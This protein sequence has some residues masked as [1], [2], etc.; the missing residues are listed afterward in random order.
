MPRASSRRRSR[1]GH[2][3]VRPQVTVRLR[4]R[5]AAW[6]AGGRTRAHLT[7]PGAGRRP[8][9][10][11]GRSSG[12][13]RSRVVEVANHRSSPGLAAN[14]LLL[15]DLTELRFRA[16]MPRGPVRASGSTRPRSGRMTSARTTGG[17]R[18]RSSAARSGARARRAPA[19]RP[20]PVRRPGK[21][22]R[23]RRPP[24]PSLRSLTRPHA[25][26]RAGSCRSPCCGR[27]S[28]TRRPGCRRE[29]ATFAWPGARPR[30]PGGN[31]PDRLAGLAAREG[32]DDH[33]VAI[34]KEPIPVRPVGFAF[35]PQV[36]RAIGFAPRIPRARRREIPELHLRRLPA[37]ERLLC[38]FQV[39]K[40]KS[41]GKGAGTITGEQE[42]D[43]RPDFDFN[44]VR[45]RPG[46]SSGPGRHRRGANARA[47]ALR[48]TGKRRGSFRGFL[49]SPVL[50]R[51]WECALGKP[52]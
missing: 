41:E 4:T 31:P 39:L 6:R 47:C 12:T 26:G 16:V 35:A 30:S 45:V 42:P 36:S 13:A 10:L 38:H 51:D 52:R 22:L 5:V 8:G 27:A 17:R 21:A 32:G 29:T 24:A 46:A 25:A 50:R 40:C 14:D 18:R 23:G 49:D 48:F 1:G 28:P 19:R 11:S 7:G 44:H 33:P 15:D 2:R 20:T 37:I 9:P 43:D 3:L 34:G